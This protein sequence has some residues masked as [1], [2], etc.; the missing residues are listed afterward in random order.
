[1]CCVCRSVAA[2]SIMPRCGKPSR[3]E[4]PG[5][6]ILRLE[7][8]HRRVI[9]E[10]KV[11]QEQNHKV[12]A[13]LKE[14]RSALRAAETAYQTISQQADEWKRKYIVADTYKERYKAVAIHREECV[15]KYVML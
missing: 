2:V 1:M 7:R 5:A 11:L 8:V 14:T 6:K 13:E 15:L 10:Q 3:S 9:R 4:E 12:V